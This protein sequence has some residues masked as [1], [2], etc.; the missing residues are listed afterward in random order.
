MMSVEQEKN[1]PNWE[2]ANTP[3]LE[4]ANRNKRL[5]LEYVEFGG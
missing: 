2:S 1:V 3:L 4:L 5:M